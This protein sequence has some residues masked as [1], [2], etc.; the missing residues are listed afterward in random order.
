MIKLT[1]IGNIGKD[2]EKR[3]INDAVVY[4]FPVA[5]NQIKKNRD[6]S[7]DQ[8]TQW[9]SCE[10][11]NP[12]AVGIIPYLTKGNGIYIEGKPIVNTYQV[13]DKTSAGLKCVVSAVEITRIID[14]GKQ[15]TTEPEQSWQ[16]FPQ[17]KT[18][19]QHSVPVKDCPQPEHDITNP[20]DDGLP[21]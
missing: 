6:G 5:V 4:N 1:F 10:W 20:A 12:K 17:K 18:P 3:E 8:Q 9:I 16:V 15:K 7:Q 13:Q 21:F 19:A 2:A 14:A 11:W